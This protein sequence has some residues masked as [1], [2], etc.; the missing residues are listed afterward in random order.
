MTNKTFT[1]PTIIKESHLDSFGHMNHGA[2]LPLLEEARWEL[3][4]QNGYGLKK[5]HETGIGPVILEINLKFLRELHARDNIIIETHLIS[6]ERTV[7]K[8]GQRI[9]R[10]GETC[11]TAELTIALFDLNQR[12]II[13]PTQEWLDAIGVEA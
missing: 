13:P 6:Y 1:Y 4:T 7:G 9:L 8:I 3:I 11:C 10:D 12:R 2:Y 5:I